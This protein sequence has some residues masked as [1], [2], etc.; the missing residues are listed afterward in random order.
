MSALSSLDPVQR[1]RLTG[2]LVGLSFGL[3]FAGLSPNVWW[4]GIIGG[5][6]LGIVVAKLFVLDEVRDEQNQRISRSPLADPAAISGISIPSDN[7]PT[8]P[9]R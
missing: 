3:I 9:A 4:A 2:F 6:V 1:K 8:S 7:E 5:I